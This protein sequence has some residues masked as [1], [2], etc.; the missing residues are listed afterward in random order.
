MPPPYTR[1]YSVGGPTGESH[2]IDKNNGGIGEKLQE[3]LF[4]P[5]GEL[6][7]ADKTRAALVCSSSLVRFARFIILG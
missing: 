5:P 7:K 6:P 1:A 2:L 4:V 3:V